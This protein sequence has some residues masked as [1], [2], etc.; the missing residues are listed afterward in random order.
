MSFMKKNIVKC[1]LVPNT[2]LDSGNVKMHQMSEG[3]LS[4][5]GWPVHPVGIPGVSVCASHR[6][7]GGSK[8]P[9]RENVSPQGLDIPVEP[10]RAR[11][12]LTCI[13]SSS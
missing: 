10:A 8:P 3:F 1:L 12:R 5:E 6:G 9:G 11:D 2:M 7:Y 13:N 4:S